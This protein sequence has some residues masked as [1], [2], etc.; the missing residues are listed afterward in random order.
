MQELAPSALH[1]L[2]ERLAA[3]KGFAGLGSTVQTVASLGDDDA[4]VRDITQAILRDAA[5]TSKLL[6]LSNASTRGMRNVATVDQAVTVL[7]LNT[8]RAVAMSLALLDTVSNKPQSR[9]LHAEVAAA[10]FCGALAARIT[11][12]NGARYSAQEAQV[13][14]LMQNLGRIMATYYLYEDIESSRALQAKEN[15]AED[16]AVTRTLGVSFEEIGEAIA[17]GWNLPDVITQSLAANA[18]KGPPRAAATAIAWH[19]QCAHFAKRVTDVLFRQPEGRERAALPQLF[20]YYRTALGLRD[21]E[22]LQWIEQVMADTSATL[23]GTGFPVSVDDARILL[24]KASEKVLDLLSSQDSLTKGL[25][26]ERK[27]IEVIHEAL[28]KTHDAF[29]FDLT[30]LL[31]PNGASGLIAV[32][33]VGRNA[34]AIAAKFRC[35][36][37]KP[38]IFRLLMTK[39]A[40]TFV[41]DVQGSTFAKL[42]PEW[43]ADLVGARAFMALSLVENGK[44]LGMLYGDYLTPHDSAPK[45]KVEGSL[46]AIRASLTTA[47]QKR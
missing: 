32:S 30:M 5:L 4:A 13:C 1:K 37:P 15:L 33:G 22:T 20:N 44:F 28:R 35:H 26:D 29:E 14:G 39:Q 8:V 45:E 23:A 10:F 36:G 7:G 46:K 31:L 19:Q 34:N 25:K 9:Q 2:N 27:P 11:R 16:E 17:Q 38:D 12:S 47:L 18:E 42:M 24:R 41:G 6:R 21:D 40:D 43:Y 3:D